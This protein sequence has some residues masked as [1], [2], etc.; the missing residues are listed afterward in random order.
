MLESSFDIIQLFG[1][2]YTTIEEK[3]EWLGIRFRAALLV[4]VMNFPELKCLY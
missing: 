1:A 2:N 3:V 4:G